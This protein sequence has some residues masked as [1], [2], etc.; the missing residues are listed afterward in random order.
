MLIIARSRLILATASLITS[1]TVGAHAGNDDG[2]LLGEQAMMTGGA[3]T[4][5]VS[6]G[7]SAWYNP[8]GLGLASRNRF[9]V[10]GSV[11]GVNIYRVKSAFALPD[12]TTANAA[13]TDW[14]LVPSVLSFVRELGDDW[15]ATVGIFIPR[16][17]DFDLRTQVQKANGEA[18]A[19][20]I[21]SQLREND[22]MMAV[23]KRLTPNLRLGVSAAGVY[24]SR[25]D[26]VQIGLGSPDAPDAGS[27][28]G[29]NSTTVGNYGAR[30]TL[31]MQWNPAPN[32]DLGL[33][34][35]SPVLTG[36]SDIS[37]TVIQ[38]T[39]SPDTGPHF[40]IEEQ[41]GP[42][43]VWEF[44]TPVR[45]R[46]GV[47]HRIGKTQLL[48]DGDIS[49]PI[50]TPSKLPP[51]V[52][53]DREWVA[54]GRVSA[55][56]TFSPNVTGG[57][58]VF[59]DLSGEKRFETNFVGAAFGVKLSQGHSVEGKRRDLTFSTTLGGRYAY[60]WGELN[61]QNL[62]LENGELRAQ[63]IGASTRVHELAFNLGGGVN[64]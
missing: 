6:D 46:A 58:G 17:H 44:T 42:V 43:A 41:R 7:A 54:N 20:T 35:Q 14:V 38:S 39:L 1:V 8:A 27:Y 36:W 62:A 26:F 15:V 61:G 60:G 57:A 64:F 40:S 37:R 56:H 47:A 50:H 2:V 32:W 59:T 12:G 19:G 31:G 22:Y 49:S 28:N 5:I 4:A 63:A 9:D 25:R 3:V 45:L 10:T 18:F 55:L 24:I 13:M 29:S 52:F 23:A 51:N 48:L 34:I 21:S 30:L 16:T 53:F 11:Y 33:S